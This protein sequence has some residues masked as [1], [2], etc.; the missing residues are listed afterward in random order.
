[1]MNTAK[2]NKK[3]RACSPK[4]LLLKWLPNAVMEKP[5]IRLTD[6]ENRCFEASSKLG[7]E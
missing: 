6:F 4:E 7:E 2:R 1:M 5:V 3:A